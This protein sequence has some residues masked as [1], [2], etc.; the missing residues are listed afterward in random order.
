MGVGSGGPGLDVRV[1]LGFVVVSS[2]NKLMLWLTFVFYFFFCTRGGG[3]AP[4][5]LLFTLL[6]RGQLRAPVPLFQHTRQKACQ[7][8]A[9]ILLCPSGAG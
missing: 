1:G 9:M 8:T 4:A 2:K 6:I 5:S 7:T 3:V